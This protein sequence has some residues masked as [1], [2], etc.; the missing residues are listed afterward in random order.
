MP[1]PSAG[2][3][4]SAMGAPGGGMGISGPWG[5][6]LQLVGGV[7]SALGENKDTKARNAAISNMLGGSNIYNQ[8]AQMS[9]WAYNAISQGNQAN[10]QRT[11]WD[12]AWWNLAN[13]PGYMPTS[14]MNMPFLQLSQGMNNNMDRF[15]GMVGRGGW[16]GGLANYGGPMAALA[17]YGMGRAGVTAN[18]ANQANQLYRQDVGMVQKAL[19][20][21]QDRAA[22]LMQQQA[23]LYMQPKSGMSQAGGIMQGVGKSMPF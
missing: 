7:F 5:M 21:P 23:Q 8:A 6:G 9:P 17:S 1:I 13:R 11:P 20:D 14:L 4:A 2:D 15:S 10:R 22:Q 3:W 19:T 12:Q 18:F 16:N